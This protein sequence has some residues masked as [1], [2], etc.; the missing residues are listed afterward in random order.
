MV[1]C[2]RASKRKG[3]GKQEEKCPQGCLVDNRRISVVFWLPYCLVGDN[4]GKI[5]HT[6]HCIYMLITL[7]LMPSTQHNATAINTIMFI[8]D[9][10]LMVKGLTGHSRH[11]PILYS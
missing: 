10:S 7:H 8:E 3:E 11:V 5:I 9:I 1:A 2:W 4:C 6:N